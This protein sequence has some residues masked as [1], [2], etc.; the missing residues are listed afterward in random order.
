[1]KPISAVL[2]I[3][4]LSVT[5]LSTA[6]AADFIEPVTDMAFVRIEGGT[7]DMGDISH[8]DELAS[9]PRKVTVNDFYMGKF[10]VTFAQYDQFCDATGRAKP[11]D[12]G[13]GRGQ[14]PVIFV[15][16]DDAM[17]FAKW[18]A[19]KAGKPYRLPSEA[20]WE[21]AARAGTSTYYWWGDQ[22]GIAL[23]NCKDCGDRWEDQT[24]PVGSFA[25]NPFGLFDMNGNVYEWCLDVRHDNYE[26][27]PTDGSAWLKDGNERFRIDRGGSWFT[28]AEELGSHVRSYHAAEEGKKHIGFRLVMDASSP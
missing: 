3:C 9:P 4:V 8:K 21:Y 22:P 28:P 2:L 6:F 7:F 1:M 16:W 13:W 14:R 18:L 27:A 11:S 23:A 26:G 12:R 17:A 15:S 5:A 10:E 25:P 19:N 24:A 20:E